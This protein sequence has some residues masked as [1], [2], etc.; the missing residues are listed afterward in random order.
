MARTTRSLI[1]SSG[2]A[3]DGCP[4]VEVK[5]KRLLS[6]CFFRIVSNEPW[7]LAPV[8]I[9]LCKAILLPAQETKARYSLCGKS[10]ETIISSFSLQLKGNHQKR[11][12]MRQLAN[13]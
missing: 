9:S 5:M 8:A 6:P 13:V 2:S 11:F 3:S 4:S 7:F 12:Q 10:R 1:V